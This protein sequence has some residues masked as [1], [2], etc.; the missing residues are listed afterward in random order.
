MTNYDEN[1]LDVLL[2]AVLIA[3]PAL[4]VL[5]GLLNHCTTQ[6]LPPEMVRE[7]V[8]PNETKSLTLKERRA[9]EQAERNNEAAL[10]QS[11]P[12]SRT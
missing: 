11:A 5:V 7:S 1:I 12:H 9:A 4:A 10:T 6:Q 8:T 2:I 3:G